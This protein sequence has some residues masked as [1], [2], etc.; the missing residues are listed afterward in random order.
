MMQVVQDEPRLKPDPARRSAGRRWP[1]RLALALVVAAALAA[2][3]VV[4]WQRWGGEVAAPA[5]ATA[6]VAKGD[7]VDVVSAL[8]NLQPR[9]YVDVG[10]QVSGQLRT[11]HV[12]LGDRV[13]QGDLLA[14]IDPTVYQSRVDADHAQLANLGAQLDEKQARLTLAQQQ[15]E[16]QQNLKRGNATSEEAVQTAAADLSATTAQIEALKAQTSQTQSQLRGDEANLGYTRIYAPMTGTVVSITARRGQTLNANQSAPIILRVAE[17]AVM[18]VVTQVSEA[19]VGRLRIGQP[20][21][22]STLG[23]PD[24]RYDSKLLQIL[25]TPEVINNVVL[26]DALLEV[27]NPDGRLMTQMTAQVFFIVGEAKGVPTV[28]ACALRPDPA[29]PGA[30]GRGIVLVPRPDGTLERREVEVGVSTRTA[31]EIRH[32]LALGEQVVVGPVGTPGEHGGR[33]RPG[34]RPRLG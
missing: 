10:T 19:E 17:L 5:Y 3:G 2:A 23:D 13:K 8:G 29:A 32:G 20:A 1:L 31:V 15:M 9:D 21:Y 22:L 12:A 24:R 26:Y 7:V 4:G 30:E 25:P 28:P 33:E 27:P 11:I 18:S 14:E 6:E 34:F 16:R